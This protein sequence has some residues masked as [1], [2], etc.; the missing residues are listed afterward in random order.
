M[1]LYTG[2]RRG[3]LLALTTRN[4]DIK[5]GILSIER[6]KTGSRL[7][8]PLVGEAL[9]IA[10]ELRDASQDGYLFPHG[11]GYPWYYYRR[12]WENALN[13]ILEFF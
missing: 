9:S 13:S 10:R 5:A 3:S 6:T 8:L 7:T 4:T 11:S 12:A 1:A 2:L